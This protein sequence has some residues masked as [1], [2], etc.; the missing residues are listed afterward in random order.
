MYSSFDIQRDI[1]SMGRQQL[2]MLGSKYIQIQEELIMNCSYVS[3]FLKFA[4]LHTFQ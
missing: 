3:S 2:S 1:D 4:Y